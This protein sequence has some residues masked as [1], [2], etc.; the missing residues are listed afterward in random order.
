MA[1]LIHKTKKITKNVNVVT[2]FFPKG[3]DHLKDNFFLILLVRFL[4]LG[5]SKQNKK[6]KNAIIEALSLLEKK[7]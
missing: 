3:S 2:L 6:Y 5:R 1:T 7:V 4:A